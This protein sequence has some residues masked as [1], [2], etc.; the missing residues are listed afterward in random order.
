MQKKGKKTM[1]QQIKFLKVFIIKLELNDA[2]M[3]QGSDINCLLHTRVHT[4]FILTIG[5]QYYHLNVQVLEGML[6]NVLK[7]KTNSKQF[8]PSSITVTSN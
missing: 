6:I 3:E 7:S 5:I 1:K 2:Y 4:R 8:R